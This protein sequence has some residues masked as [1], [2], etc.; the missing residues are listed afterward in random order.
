MTDIIQTMTTA[1]LDHLRPLAVRSVAIVHPAPGSPLVAEVAMADACVR[2]PL[3]DDL[4][5]GPTAAGREV[6]RVVRAAMHGRGQP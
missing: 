6:A 3:P 5:E 2:V 1:I 4:P